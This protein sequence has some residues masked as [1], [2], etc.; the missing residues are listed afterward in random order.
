MNEA[1][2]EEADERI[3]TAMG[4]NRYNF[5]KMMITMNSDTRDTSADHGDSTLTMPLMDQTL[6][7]RQQIRTRCQFH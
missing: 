6:P 5:N 1:V 7:V 2:V 4:K 3:M